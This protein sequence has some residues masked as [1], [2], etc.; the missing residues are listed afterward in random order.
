MTLRDYTTSRVT[1]PELHQRLTEHRV[2]LVD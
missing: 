2:Q 1:H